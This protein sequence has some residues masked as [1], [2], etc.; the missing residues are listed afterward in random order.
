M[1]QRNHKEVL[2]DIREHPENHRHTFDGLTTCC[3][4]NGAIDISIMDAH[5]G[6]L[7]QNGGR[8]C[9]VTSGPCAC[10]ATH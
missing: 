5:E 8:K 10:G 9:D 2:R 1:N 4:I 3:M 7:G 6:I